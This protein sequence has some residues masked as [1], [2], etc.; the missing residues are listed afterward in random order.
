MKASF[1]PS[2]H[3]SLLITAATTQDSAVFTFFPGGAPAR[4]LDALAYRYRELAPYVKLAGPTS[5][6]PAIYQVGPHLTSGLYLV[7]DP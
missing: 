7:T 4:G 1:T 5:F 6:A 2:A 3:C